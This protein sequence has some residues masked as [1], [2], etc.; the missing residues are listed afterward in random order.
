[1]ENITNEQGVAIYLQQ[2]IS[3]LTSACLLLRTMYDN[4][5]AVP[6]D[7][8]A[9]DLMGIELAITAILYEIATHEN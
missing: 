1:M 4:G 8:I 2:S 3:G 7:E 9:K 5:E 6:H